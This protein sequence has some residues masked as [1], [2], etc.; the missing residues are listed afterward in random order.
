MPRLMI[1]YTLC[2]EYGNHLKW[3]I[4]F[5]GDWHVLFNYQ[6][7][8]MKAYSDAGLVSSAW[9]RS[10]PPGRDSDQFDSVLELQKDTCI[11]DAV[12]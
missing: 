1:C 11:L 6:P 7:V 8:L 9:Y 4:P 3:L 12:L 2:V 10:W 5:P